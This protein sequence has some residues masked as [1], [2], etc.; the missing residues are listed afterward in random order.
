MRNILTVLAFSASLLMGVQTVSAQTLKQ[1]ANRPEVIAK[2]EAHDLTQSLGLNGDQTRAIFRALVTHK[3]D[4]QKVTQGKD[5][6]S[7]SVQAEKQ[8]VDATLKGTMEKILTE[9][10]YNTWLEDFE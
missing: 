4:V 10:Q 5:V 2:E 7:P 6:N 9:E 3:V 8:K 1:D